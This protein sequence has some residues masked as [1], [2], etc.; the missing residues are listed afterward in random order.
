MGVAEGR[1]NQGLGDLLM[2][3]VI[4]HV[5]TI[6]E[7]VAIRLLV[8]DAIDEGVVGFYEKYGF[9]TWPTDS[10]RLF[11]RVKDLAYTFGAE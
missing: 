1:Q 7:H 10:L 6:G 9:V 8:V 4:N 3:S 5:L 11:A 2:R